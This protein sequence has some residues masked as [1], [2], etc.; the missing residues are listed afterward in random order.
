MSRRSYAKQLLIGT[1]EIVM[2][3]NP[4]APHLTDTTMRRL[5]YE[6]DGQQRD[7]ADVARDFLRASGVV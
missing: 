5:N 6:I 2:I 7:P 4:L 3:L 1:R